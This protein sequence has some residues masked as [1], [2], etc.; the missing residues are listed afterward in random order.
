MR[1]CKGIN[2]EIR[3]IHGVVSVSSPY[4]CEILYM[5]DTRGCI[6]LNAGASVIQKDVL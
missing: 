1:V 2:L 6:M 3:V 5:Q 4:F